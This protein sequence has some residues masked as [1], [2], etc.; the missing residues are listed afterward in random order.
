MAWGAEGTSNCHL[1]SFSKVT[2]PVK[3]YLCAVAVGS[4]PVEPFVAEVFEGDRLLRRK[5]ELEQ[6]VVDEI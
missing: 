3:T 5:R 1:N 2:E 4:F 6:T